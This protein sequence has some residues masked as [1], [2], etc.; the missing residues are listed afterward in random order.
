MQLL[1]WF[2]SGNDDHPAGHLVQLGL[3]TIENIPAAHKSHIVFVSD[4]WLKPA[5]QD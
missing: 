2:S 3:P 4:C 1:R 5:G